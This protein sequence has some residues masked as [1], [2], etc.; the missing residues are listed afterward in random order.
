MFMMIVGPVG[1]GKSILLRSIAGE[2]TLVRGSFSPPP[3]GVAF[4]SQSVWLRNASVRDNIIGEDEFEE[5]WYNS[6]VWSCGLLKDFAEMKTGDQTSI[7]SKGISLSG[8]QKNR[9]VLARAL[10]SRKPVFLIDDMIAGLDNTTEKLVF[11]RVFS[12]NGLLR[13]M[14]VTVLLATHATHFARHADRVLVISAG[15]IVEH[16]TYKELV[17]GGK[18]DPLILGGTV[19]IQQDRTGAE[20]DIQ[21]LQSEKIITAIQDQDEDEDASRQAG[22][23]RSLLF[24]PQAIGPF[25]T[26]LY[27]GLL[28]VTT[29]ATTIQCGSLL[30]DD[31]SKMLIVPNS[32]VAQMV[33]TV[34]RSQQV[35]H[36][37]ESVLVRHHNRGQHH[38]IFHMDRVSILPTLEA[39]PICYTFS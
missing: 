32:P 13:K 33:G 3:S 7:G 10:Y 17:D 8:G 37:Q 22:D 9:I 25:H 2:T 5:S 35:R 24:F 38:H 20:D 14:G 26:A 15:R 34:Q 36:Y 16:A 29:V 12:T 31:Y 11:D 27:F 23:S 39:F 30:G 18:V 1:S 4:C 28:V 19:S 6:V 21:P